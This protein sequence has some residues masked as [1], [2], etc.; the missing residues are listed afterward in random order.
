MEVNDKIITIYLYSYSHIRTNIK[1]I[2]STMVP[3]VLQKMRMQR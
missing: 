2:Y 1:D 3:L